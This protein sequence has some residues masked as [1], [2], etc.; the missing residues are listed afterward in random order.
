MLQL[1]PRAALDGGDYGWLKARHHFAVSDLGNRDHGPVGPIVVWNDDEIAPG[2]GFGLHGHANME[3]ISYVRQGVVTHRD[4][5]GNRGVTSAGDVQVMSAGTGVRHSEHNEGKEPLKLFQI[6]LRPR[7][8]G[9]EPFWNSRTFPK[10]NRSDRWTMLA[11][12]SPDDAD[13]LPMRADA[14]VYG[15]SIRSGASLPYRFAAG[16]CAYVAAATGSVLINGLRLEAG[17]GLAVTDEREITISAI[18]DSELILV[19]A[20]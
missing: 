14:R 17:D 6:W 20:A 8:S 9:G 12:G 1:R 3:I 19:D 7:V 2:S 15:T 18:D 4:S 10:D 13:A 5:L 11:S 16:H